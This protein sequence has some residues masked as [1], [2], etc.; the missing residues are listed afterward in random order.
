V[1]PGSTPAG[2]S[3]P[4]YSPNNQNTPGTAGVLPGSTR[5][6]FSH[7]IHSPNTPG[8][9]G[10]LPGST[11][12]APHAQNKLARYATNKKNGLTPVLKELH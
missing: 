10:V 5:V 4:I 11:R 6:E 1:L 7:P 9:A 12:V 3:H 8:T 2:F